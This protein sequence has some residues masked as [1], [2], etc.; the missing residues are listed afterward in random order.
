MIQWQFQFK[1]LRILLAWLAA[2]L[3]IY[4]SKISDP[5]FLWGTA[6]I[7]LGELIRLWSL[8]FVE[9]K[10]QRLAMS[11]P[12][13]FI[14]NPLYFGNFFLGLGV[15][16][17]CSNGIIAA[18]FITGFTIMYLG[19]IRQEEKELKERFGKTYEDYCKDVPALF[20]RLFPYAAPEKDFFDWR[21]IFKHHEYVTVLGI[22][23]LLCGIHLYDEIFIEKELF[24]TQRGLIFFTAIVA[25]ILILERL[26]ISRL[27]ET[28][29][30]RFKE[31]RQASSKS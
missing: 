9:K 6:L 21:R 26:F 16:V 23:L 20:P 4:Y 29:I 31:S 8:G 28:F 10:G 11:G 7:L 25:I 3:L 14:R 2:P 5:S 12:Y 24:S 18:I 17:I 19:T 30:Q 22:I 27:P 15:I 13:A 1:K